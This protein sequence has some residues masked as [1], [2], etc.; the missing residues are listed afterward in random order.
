[1]LV[2]LQNKRTQLLSKFRADDRLVVEASQEI[3]DTQAALDNAKKQT[4]TDQATDVNP[5]HQALELDIAKEQAD[6][7]VSKPAARFWRNSRTL[8]S[9]S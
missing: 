8:I 1:M 4:G 7:L 2:E 9:S 5:V 6:S 3:A